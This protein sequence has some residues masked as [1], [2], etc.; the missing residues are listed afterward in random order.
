MGIG[1]SVCQSMYVCIYSRW[2]ISIKAR[3]KLQNKTVISS[4]MCE[5]IQNHHKWYYKNERNE[6]KIYVYIYIKDKRK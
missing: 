1:D 2:V 4:Y 6:P 3:D 5:N